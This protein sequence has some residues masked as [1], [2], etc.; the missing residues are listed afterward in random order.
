MAFTAQVLDLRSNLKTANDWSVYQEFSLV[1]V[2][3]QV[4]FCL[5][6]YVVLLVFWQLL[7]FKGGALFGILGSK[8]VRY[9]R[10]PIILTGFLTQ[11]VGFFLIFLNIPDN[12]PFG[13]TTDTAFIT[14]R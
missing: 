14:S 13:D 8:T 4:I 6:L 3:L 1:S 11:A 5:L 9:G 7:M 10:D 2:K 12:A